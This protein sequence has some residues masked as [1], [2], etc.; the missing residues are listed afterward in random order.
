MIFF[1]PGVGGAGK[2]GGSGVRTAVSF[3]S[4]LLCL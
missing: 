1:P 3:F 2:V 4:V